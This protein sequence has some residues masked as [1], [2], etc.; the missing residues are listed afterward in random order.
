ME[1]RFGQ[2]RRAALTF[3]LI[4]VVLPLTIAPLAAQ[5]ETPVSKL[6][7]YQGCSEP[8]YDEWVR[9]SQ[10]IT[11]R[12]GTRLAVDVFR[13]PETERRSPN[14]CLQSGRII[15]ITGRR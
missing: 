10:Y 4:L 11:V 9:T 8:I 3:L 12:D 13:P 5:E 1:S 15:A 6:G 2:A 7:E 14:L